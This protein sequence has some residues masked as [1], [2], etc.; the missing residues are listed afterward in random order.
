MADVLSYPRMKKVIEARWA[1]QWKQIENAVVV[2]DYISQLTD[3]YVVEDVFA[4]QPLQEV[5]KHAF[6][7]DYADIE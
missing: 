6:G 3:R 7:V 5:L 1:D 4:E 2:V